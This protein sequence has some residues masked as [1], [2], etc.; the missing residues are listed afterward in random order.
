MELDW[1]RAA[2]KGFPKPV[3]QVY[4]FT[5]SDDALK[6]EAV[7]A[8]TT[9][10]L[11]ES[12]ADFDREE[13]DIPASGEG[14]EQARRILASVGSVPM[15]SER[16]VT[17]V[18]G[19]QKL[20]K[21]DADA[22]AAA[23]PTLGA[24][25]CLVLVAGATEYEAGK[26][27]GG[28]VSIKL[29][30]AVGKA[31]VV[32][33]CEAPGAADLKGRVLSLAKERGKTIAPDAVEVLT[34][35]AL[36]YGAARGGKGGDINAL[37]ADMDKVLAYVGERDKVTR[38]DALA[39]GVETADDNI[40]ALLDAVGHRDAARA[41]AQADELLRAE[42]KPDGVAARTF[43]MLAR[44]LRLLWGAK[45]LAEKRL[46]GDR[47]RGGLP[48]DVASV[49]SGEMAGLALRQSFL[50]RGLQD[51][52]RGW[53]YDALRWAQGRV[54]TSDMTLKGMHQLKALEIRAPGEDP[55]SN[56]RLL[57]VELCGAGSAPL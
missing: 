27:K 13:M 20:S 55:A 6:R 40:F 38:A 54:L 4:L 30:N 23:I 51:Q 32:V 8:L 16:R 57:V 53:S 9:P 33:L 45:Y 24:L 11:D 1:A 29:S 18:T 46:T 43:V 15:L 48:P 42:G 36:E 28:T 49:L 2:A 19:V 7:L 12:M 17:I 39:V 31:G 5:G 34:R 56:L 22:L 50:L 37:H 47:L 41:V 52:A 10:L 14:G 35:R 44:H 25:S 26:I 3:A 21:P